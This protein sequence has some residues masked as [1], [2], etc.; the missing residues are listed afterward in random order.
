MDAFLYNAAPCRVVFGDGSLNKLADEV[1]A[2][3]LKRVMVLTTPHQAGQGQDVADL[4]GSRCVVQF[5]DATMHTPVDV[6]SRAASLA[7]EC[8]ADGTVAIGGGSTIGLGKALTLRAGL[9]QIAIPTTYAGSEMTPILGQTE[10]GVKTTMKDDALR[11]KTVIYDVELT[12]GLPVGMSVTSGLNAIA[13]SMEALYA[14]DRNP[15]V[16]LM[17]EEGIRAVGS[18]L[19]VLC[20]KPDDPSARSEALYGA[21]LCSLCLGSVGMSLHH[22][23]CHTLGGAF[24]LPHAET[25]S[26]ILPHSAVY[27]A[28]AAPEAMDR[29][30]RALG[31]DDGN[32]P[33]ALA[34]L[35]KATGAP[36]ALR[37]IGMPEDG[38]NHA[39]DLAARNPYW[40]PTPID[41]VEI[42]KLLKNAWAGH[43]PS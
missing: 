15:V 41:Q 27:N 31:K 43:L 38:I 18:A 24:D 17:A 5:N 36:T 30:A 14:Q 23:L 22:K 39:A 35:A 9:P 42:N 10:D 2:L 25:H 16:S 19:P 34:S 21:W 29:I 20:E 11:P 40:N 13:H 28:A 37:D 12:L 33:A 4:L 6:T 26:I 7:E 32:G 1:E 3:G 8:K